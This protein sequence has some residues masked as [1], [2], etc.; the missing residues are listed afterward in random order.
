M[1][2]FLGLISLQTKAMRD[3]VDSKMNTN[4]TNKSLTDALFLDDAMHL[5]RLA[6][7]KDNT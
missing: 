5:M 7:D 6:S 2:M 4:C 1:R 3:I